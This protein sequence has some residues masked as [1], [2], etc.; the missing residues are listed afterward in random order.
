MQSLSEHNILIFLIQV[1]LLL[2]L[3]RMLGELFRTWKQPTIT[4]EILIGVLLGPTIFGRFFPALHLKIFPTDIIQQNMLETVAW[5]GLLFF[6]LEAGLKMDFSSAW[7]HRG[8]ALTI[9]LTDIIVPMTIAFSCSY[10]LPAQYLVDPNQRI[11]FAL[12][13]A[14]A[15]T[16]SA[17]P[18]T[19]RVLNDLN[20]A[21][22]DI[23]FLIMSALSVNE[24][25]GWMI[26]TLVLGIFI[27]TTIVLGEIL[28][29]FFLAIV[30]T[31]FCL[32]VGRRFANFVILR[33][34]ERNMP[35]PGSSLTFICLLGLLCGAIFQRI[36][37]HALLGFFIAGVVAGEVR[38][39]PERTRHIISQMVYAIFVPLFFA[40]IG[41]GIDFFKNFNLFL[42][43]FVTIIG[44]CGK[45]LGAWLG[46]TFTSLPRINRMSV[47]IAHTPG[48]AM[49]IVIGILA[50]KYNLIS[51]PM[52]VAIVFGGVLSAMILGPWL[53]HSLCGRK[54]IGVLEF[55]SHREIV[56]QLKAAD[57]DNAIR[58]L[59]AIASEQGN[60]PPADK[61]SAEVL[62]RESSMGTAI[63]EGI[64]LPHARIPALIR[65]M[66]VFGR[67]EFG[68]DWDSPD[69]TPSHFI[70]L[71][72]TPKED[73]DIQVQILRIIARSMS[74]KRT[75]KTL[76]AAADEQAIWQVLQESFTQQ[77]V[78]RKGNN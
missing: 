11:I 47:A 76:M 37:M 60:L 41:L 49:E 25:I 78:V 61:L 74:H 3:A 2:G 45:F 64:A 14:T 15:M 9:A 65:P 16:I 72:L 6:L 19:I 34:R 38:A 42:V 53:K 56:A 32:T 73:D 39:L 63:E 35:E 18:I 26:F 21:K 4:A 29:V 54:T 71:I 43:L 66:V 75:Q 10:F 36:G 51:Q 77:E 1:F 5:L 20:V 68:I 58:E 17:M 30:F 55:F 24:I 69:G 12:F 22:T 33:I 7:R 40:R 67:S 13:M 70:F 31:I 28:I 52:F 62:R 8:K 44:I 48:G 59:C 50:L 46:V 27:Q 23:G 57:R